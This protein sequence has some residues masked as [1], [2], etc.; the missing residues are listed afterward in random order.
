MNS[1][2]VKAEWDN[3]ASVWVAQSDDVPGLAAESPTLELLRPKVIL[4]IADLIEENQIPVL[5]Y[6]KFL[7]TLWPTQLNE[8]QFLAQPKLEF[9]IE[10]YYKSRFLALIRF[11]CA[12]R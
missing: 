4:M 10:L 6:L 8:W 9:K 1:I 2:I 5:C 3:E 11:R 12:I 7:C